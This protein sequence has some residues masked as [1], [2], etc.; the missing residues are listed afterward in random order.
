MSPVPMFTV[1]RNTASIT[2]MRVLSLTIIDLRVSFISANLASMSDSAPATFTD[3]A[4]ANVS[5]R[6]PVIA[7]V[8][9]RACFRYRLTRPPVL[10]ETMPTMTMGRAITTVINGSIVH[11][12]NREMDPPTRAPTKSTKRSNG[13]TTCSMSSRNRLTTSPG[14]SSR[15]SAP[16]N[17]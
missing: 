16:G 11:R 14:D 7:S 15:P 1:L 13:S 2:A 3:C 8:A 9:S 12:M 5:P 4:A 17:S 10:F 6:N